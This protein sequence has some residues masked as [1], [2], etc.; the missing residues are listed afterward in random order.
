MDADIELAALLAKEGWQKERLGEYQSQRQALSRFTIGAVL[1]TDPVVDVIRRELRR[2]SPDAKIESD[3]IVKVL[4]DD[5]L[6]RDVME[7]DK[8]IA[9]KR[10][11]ARAGNRT[12]RSSRSDS[13]DEC[14][15]VPRPAAVKTP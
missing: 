13:K 3:D 6:K 2:V 5:L 15:K 4:Q 7:G 10:I 12:L 14:A 9:A 1:L 11:V 8:A